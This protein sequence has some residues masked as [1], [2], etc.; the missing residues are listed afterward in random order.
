MNET[1]VMLTVIV[2]FELEE[3]VADALLA[4]PD[5][6]A[7]FTTSDVEGHGSSIKLVEAAELVCGH[8]RR[9][10]LET[11]CVSQARAEAVLALLHQQFAGA[12]LFYWI[13]PVLASGRL[14]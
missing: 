13:M 1:Q 10:R 12:N 6:S 5:L 8:V 14:A 11:L 7:G 4:R 3:A 9:K 2:P